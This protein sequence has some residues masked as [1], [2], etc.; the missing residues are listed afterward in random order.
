MGENVNEMPM[1]M[2]SITRKNGTIYCLYIMDLL[3]KQ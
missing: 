2:Y 1:S 3:E